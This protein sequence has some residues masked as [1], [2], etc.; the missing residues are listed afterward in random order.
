M[1]VY[2]CVAYIVISVVEYDYAYD[3]T[4]RTMGV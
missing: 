3:I 2:C 4:S 1:H